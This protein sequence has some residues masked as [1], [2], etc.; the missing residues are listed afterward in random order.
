LKRRNIFKSIEDLNS[1]CFNSPDRRE[2]KAVLA[3]LSFRNSKGA[4]KLEAFLVQHLENK[5]DDSMGITQ[6]NAPHEEQSNSS[7]KGKNTNLTEIYLNDAQLNLVTVR[8]YMRENIRDNLSGKDQMAII[9]PERSYATSRF[10]FSML[11][12]V[13]WG[14]AIVGVLLAIAGL[15]TGGAGSFI[16]GGTSAA[17]DLLAMLPG[18]ALTL[19][20]LVSVASVRSSRAYVETAELTLEMLRLARRKIKAGGGALV[21]KSTGALVKDVACRLLP[22]CTIC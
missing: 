2:L 18:L 7:D 21:T 8:D 15:Q 5:N 10:V 11:E 6:K 13:G 16:R 3:E 20:G 14:T 4:K 9:S 12:V 19:G 22:R 17:Q 1:I